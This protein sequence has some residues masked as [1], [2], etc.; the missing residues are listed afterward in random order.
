V[1][2]IDAA[3]I[4][5]LILLYGSACDSGHSFCVVNASERVARVLALVGLDAILLSHNAVPVSHFNSM[6]RPVAA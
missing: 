6:N 1:E 4:T 5:A 3:G 2:R